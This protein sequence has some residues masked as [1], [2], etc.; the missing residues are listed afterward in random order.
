MDLISLKNSLYINQHIQNLQKILRNCGERIEGNLICDISAD[1]YTIDNNIHKIYNLQQL[2]KGKSKICEIGINASHSLLLMLLVNPT[3]EYLLFDL[4]YHSYTEP[5]LKYIMSSFPNTKI[6]TIFGDS[7]KTISQYIENHPFEINMYDFSH[8][9]GG[10]LYEVFS[11]DFENIKIL[12]KKT[13]VIIFDDFDLP[14]I[15]KFISHKVNTHEINEYKDPS[16]I[17]NHLQYI[18]TYHL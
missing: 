15:K 6:T 10:H 13:G 3:A 14:D 18:Y 7:V 16:L 9:D 2:A 12:S 5:C 17:P 8:I 4:N 1:N 11:K